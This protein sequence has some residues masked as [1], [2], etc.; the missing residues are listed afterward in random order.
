MAI[1]R[2]Q[3]P[4]SAMQLL[5]QDMGE[6]ASRFFGRGWPNMPDW[7]ARDAVY[8]AVDIEDCDNELVVRMDIPGAKAEELKVDCNGNMLTI[9]GERKSEKSEKK[10]QTLYTERQYGSFS[11][12]LALPTLVKQDQ[13]NARYKDGVLELHL[14][15]AEETKNKKIKIENG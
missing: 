6:L 1:T 9:S 12:Q 11:R 7:P 10:G 4:F 5:N 14:P 15:K 8:T 2:Y 13:V 3:G